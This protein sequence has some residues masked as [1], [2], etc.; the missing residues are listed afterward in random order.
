MTNI[1]FSM[2]I[3]GTGTVRDKPN[4]NGQKEA[5]ALRKAMKGIGKTLIQ[6]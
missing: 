3:Q 4:F 6:F 2:H 1:L 5:E